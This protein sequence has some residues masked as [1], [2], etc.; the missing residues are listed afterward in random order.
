MKAQYKFF[1]CCCKKKQEFDPDLVEH[2]EIHL[3]G[4]GKHGLI[5]VFSLMQFSSIFTF[6]IFYY[7]YYI[8]TCNPAVYL[9]SDELPLSKIMSYDLSLQI[10]MVLAI[11]MKF[12]SIVLLSLALDDYQNLSANGTYLIWS[13]FCCLAPSS[14]LVPVY[15]Y[16]HVRCMPRNF[17]LNNFTAQNMSHVFFLLFFS[18][19]IFS[20]LI[21]NTYTNFFCFFCCK[22]KSEKVDVFVDDNQS[23]L[24]NNGAVK[25]KEA[26]ARNTREKL[27]LLMILFLNTIGIL[28]SIV[29]VGAVVIVHACQ[30]KLFDGEIL[31]SGAINEWFSL[32]FLLIISCMHKQKEVTQEEIEKKISKIEIALQK[33]IRSR[34]SVKMGPVGKAEL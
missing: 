27:S 15:A 24:A 28:T 26:K 29:L 12:G 2:V 13:I 34:M 20:L 30:Y 22:R 7:Q 8:H 25:A 21:P 32:L 11:I 9:V 16:D 3:D 5:L 18:L 6:C 1:G 4:C 14:I 23:N 33:S 10:N 19:F 31:N 17:A